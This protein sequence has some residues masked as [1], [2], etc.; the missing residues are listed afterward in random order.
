MDTLTPHT[1]AT[2]HLIR[3]ASFD[4]EDAPGFAHALEQAALSF[5]ETAG[6]LM[7]APLQLEMVNIDSAAAGEVLDAERIG[8]LADVR[9]ENWD[10][11]LYLIAPRASAF[12]ILEAL[13]GGDDSGPAIEPERE[14]TAI[15][16]ATVQLFFRQLQDDIQSSFK[17]DAVPGL[18]L[19]TCANSIELEEIGGPE[20]MFTTVLFNAELLGRPI[21]LSLAVPQ[22]ALAAN[23][24]NLQLD[25][26]DDAVSGDP[27]WSTHFDREARRADVSLTAVLNGGELSL[28]DISRLREGQVLELSADTDSLVK[29]QCNDQPMLW[30][31]L[32]QSDGAFV[33]RV[34]QFNDPE[35]G[36][37]DEL[38][39]G[40]SGFAFAQGG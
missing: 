26:E 24:D 21:E 32:G 17:G 2:D 12:T 16:A 33:L 34:E 19:L 36:L 29:V 15:E 28:D 40:S 22:A 27:K 35:Q 8:L 11:N 20:I 37:V 39:T 3:T 30:C 9:A 38:I 7:E 13:F 10:T 14:F 23:R 31:R 1:S 18:E 4:I 25:P 5:S 6:K